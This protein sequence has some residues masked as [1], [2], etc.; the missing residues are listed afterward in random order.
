MVFHRFRRTVG[1][2]KHCFNHLSISVVHDQYALKP[3]YSSFSLP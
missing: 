3:T 1:L 2:F